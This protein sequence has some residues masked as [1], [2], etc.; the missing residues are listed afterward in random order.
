MEIFS[1]I[2]AIMKSFMF[3]TFL[4]FYFMLSTWA[5]VFATLFIAG[6]LL[7]GFIVFVNSQIDKDIG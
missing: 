4:F 7:W 1:W 2:W 5:E 6:L 3:W